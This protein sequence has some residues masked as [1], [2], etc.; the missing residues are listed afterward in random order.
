MDLKAVSTK[1][2]NGSKSAISSAMNMA[3]ACA[4]AFAPF[5]HRWD[6]EADRRMALRTPENLKALIE[7]QKKNTSARATAAT[8]KAQR[9][10]ARKSS[11]V[12]SSS[13][14]AA[15]TAD[16]A[17]S[18]HAK[19]ARQGLDAARKNYPQPLA[20]LAVKLHALHAVPAVAA[21]YVMSDAGDWTT[22]PALTS[23][24]LI[25]LNT[26]ALWLGRR[27]VRVRLDDDLSIEERQLVERLDPAFWVAHAE[28]R[29]LGGTVTTPPEVTQA[30][31]E[32]G[33][34]LDGKWSTDALK[35]AEANVRALLG[36]RTELPML[37]KDGSRGGWA[38]MVFRTRSA[39]D[40]ADLRWTPGSAF[41]VDTVTGEEKVIRLGQRMLIAGRSGAGKSWSARPLLFE[42]SDGEAHALVIIDLKKV[43]AR[44]WEHRARTASTP[45][46]VIAVV[47]ELVE[48]MTERLD[49]VPRGEDTIQP[50]RD[51]PRITVFVDEGAEVMTNAKAALEG[52]ESIARMGRAACID[53][54][55]ATQKPTMSGASAGIPAQIAPQLSTVVCLSV[56]TPTETRTVLG[57]DAQ[58]KGWNADELPAPG[59]ALVRTDSPKD[60][61]NPVKTRALSPKDVIALP[62]QPIWQRKGAP[63]R[64]AGAPDLGPLGLRLIKDGDFL[65]APP[66]TEAAAEVPAQKRPEPTNREKVAAA[67]RAGAKTAADV[68][69]VTGINK[70]TVSKAVKSLVDAGEIVKAEDGTL[71]VATTQAG[72]VSA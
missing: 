2:A 30:G 33:V 43:E 51:L 36:V 39:A 31:I 42:A 32:C 57:E 10:A 54:W 8:A 63:A 50:T 12:L 4:P 41:G 26:G 23:A 48:E 9:Q 47:A 69:L 6:A 68:A 53:L 44:L 17:A 45:A 24:G 49:L 27:E 71:S 22:W 60:R 64:S 34:R 7:A 46:D 29:G 3:D 40:G 58:A 35:K 56:R 16:R 72:E 21:T 25:A 70:G 28:E 62:D 11:S 19:V 18:G 13:R 14:R 65:L 59:Y 52:L 37:V 5:A 20:R 61:P 55:W 66:A 1:I 67:I 15:R 38:V